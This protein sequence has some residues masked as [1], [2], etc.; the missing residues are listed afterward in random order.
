NTPGYGIAK[1][2]NAMT[3]ED[4]KFAVGR[5]WDTDET[6][7][8]KMANT[9]IGVHNSAFL[10]LIKDLKEKETANDVRL[11]AIEAKLGMVTPGKKA[12]VTKT[13]K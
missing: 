13:K 3:I 12:T 8:I 6:E 2:P 7:G 4:F 1:H 9:V 11:K 5:S 10:H